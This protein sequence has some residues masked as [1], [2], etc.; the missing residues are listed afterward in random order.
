MTTVLVIVIVTMLV[1]GGTTLS[2]MEYLNIKTGCEYPEDSLNGPERGG[3]FRRLGSRSDSDASGMNSAEAGRLRGSFE[4]AVVRRNS[5]RLPEETSFLDLSQVHG[6]ATEALVKFDH[7]FVRP[8]FTR[9]HSDMTMESDGLTLSRDEDGGDEEE[10]VYGGDTAKYDN[11][12]DSGVHTDRHRMVNGNARYASSTERWVET[13]GSVAVEDEAYELQ[14][15]S[16]PQIAEEKTLK[17][18]R[19]RL[20]LR[21]SVGV[22]SRNRSPSRE[23]SG[24][25]TGSSHETSSNPVEGPAH[26]KVREPT[27]ELVREDKNK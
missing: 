27:K 3:R 26:V 9:R 20:G 12:D 18:S 8:F 25:E 23:A 15:L 14:P 16:S 1:F 19:T 22:E 10:D 6:L 13:S 4:S 17:E 21:G 11:E 7:N 24:R 5:T 2:M